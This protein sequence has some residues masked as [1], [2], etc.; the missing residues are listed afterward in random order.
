[1]SPGPYNYINITSPSTPAGPSTNTQQQQNTNYLN[2]ANVGQL[3]LTR[4]H[5]ASSG[6]TS[7]EGTDIDGHGAETQADPYRAYLDPRQP[8]T[9]YNFAGLPTFT[10]DGAGVQSAL[11]IQCFGRIPWSEVRPHTGTDGN[12]LPVRFNDAHFHPMNYTGAGHDISHLIKAAIHLGVGKFVLMAIPTTL[13][14]VQGDERNYVVYQGNSGHCGEPYYVPIKMAHLTNLDEKTLQEIQKTVQL[15]YNEQVDY[16]LTLKVKQA[17]EN[18]K[19]RVEHLDKIDIGMT[20][21][22]PLSDPNVVK[23]MVKALDDVRTKNIDLRANMAAKGI[24][25]GTHRLRYTHVG[26]VT[27][28]KEI[29]N[30]IFGGYQAELKKNIAPTR[31]A[32]RFAGIV[33]MPFVLHC[34]V[35]TPESLKSWRQKNKPPVNLADIKKLMRSCPNTEII[36]AHAGGLGRFVKEGQHHLDELERLMQDPGLTHVKLDISWSVVADQIKADP[37]AIQRWAQFMYTYNER[38]L[39]GSDALTPN[40]NEK[41]TETYDKYSEVNGL[42][43]EIDRLNAA[44]PTLVGGLATQNIR[45][46]NYD[47]VFTAARERV[48]CFTDLVIPEVID[49]I[50]HIKGPANVDLETMQ[51]TRD[52]VYLRHSDPQT[53]KYDPRAVRTRNHFAARDKSNA[54][55]YVGPDK[56]RSN[57]VLKGAYNRLTFGKTHKEYKPNS[58]RSGDFAANKIRRQE[59]ANLRQYMNRFERHMVSLEEHQWFSA[60]VQTMNRVDLQLNSDLAPDG[61]MR[62]ARHIMFAMALAL[63]GRAGNPVNLGAPPAILL[64]KIK[65]KPPGNPPGGPA[66]VNPAA[67]GAIP[68][69]GVNLGLPPPVAP[70]PGLNLGMPTIFPGT[71][72]PPGGGGGGGGS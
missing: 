51:A 72:G 19:I 70:G 20:G 2:V 64:D 61:L 44:D 47:R 35:D 8:D 27:V 50:R 28:Q 1:M 56:Q 22:V 23:E 16:E 17:V 59:A 67:A 5:T 55:F 60:I 53:Q 33:G 66:V 25:M 29:V 39:F 14:N 71:G 3:P 34:D 24:D 69:G 38:I 41:W 31:E 62:E 11:D 48:D 36:W 4:T 52:R 42:F 12:P 32:M 58:G 30:K 45:V 37:A 26:E 15:R 54:Q 68:P 65:T 43:A 40:L 49:G 46:N 10:F 13:M 63:T 57:Q 9:E 7:P 18:D 6:K 21:C